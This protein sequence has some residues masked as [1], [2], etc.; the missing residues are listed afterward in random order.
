MAR[1]LRAGQPE[2]ATMFTMPTIHREAQSAM[3]TAFHNAALAESREAL[4]PVGS[5]LEQVST[6]LWQWGH[7]ANHGAGRGDQWPGAL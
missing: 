4:G 7:D 2:E 3:D 6:V 5:V 1:S